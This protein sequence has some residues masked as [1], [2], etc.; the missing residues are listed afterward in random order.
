MVLNQEAEVTFVNLV[1]YPFLHQLPYI[2]IAEYMKN[3][4]IGLMAILHKHNV[5]T[6]TLHEI[7]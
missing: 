2:S 6:L 7:K 1:H 3:K 5:F 4:E